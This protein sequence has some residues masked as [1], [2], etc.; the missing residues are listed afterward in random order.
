MG[1]LPLQGDEHGEEEDHALVVDEFE[2][3]PGFVGSGVV[4]A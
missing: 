2:L 3:G 1:V 4:A